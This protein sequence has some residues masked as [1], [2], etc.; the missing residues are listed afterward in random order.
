MKNGEDLKIISFNVRSLKKHFADILKDEKILNADVICLSETWISTDT[1]LSE[2]KLP[3]FESMS[4]IYGAG[5]GVTIYSKNQI[6]NF[7]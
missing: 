5:K 2:L 1:E 7:K 3:N 6:N 4:S